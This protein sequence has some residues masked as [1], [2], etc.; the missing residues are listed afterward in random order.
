[1]GVAVLSRAQL[2]AGAPLALAVARF[3]QEGWRDRG[4]TVVVL[5]YGYP[6]TVSRPF[7]EVASFFA[8]VSR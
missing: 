2:A 4:L 3:R 7:I 8:G 1:M 5:A 6:H